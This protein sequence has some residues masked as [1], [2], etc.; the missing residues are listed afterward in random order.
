MHNTNEIPGA[1]ERNEI[2]PKPDIA[3]RKGK[4]RKYPVRVLGVI[5]LTAVILILNHIASLCFDRP[6][7]AD[8]YNYDMA[9][10]Q[11]DQAPVDMIIVG[12]SQV[13]HGCN[14]MVISEQMNIGE[15]VDCGAAVG[16]ADGLYYMLRDLLRRFTPECV[17][18]DMPWHRFREY[19]DPA[20]RTGMYLCSDRLNWSDKLDYALHCYGLKDW[21]NLVPVYRYGE[22]V[23]SLGQLLKNYHNKK[24]VAEGRWEEAGKTDY[25]K[26]GFKWTRKSCPQGSIPALDEFYSEEQNSEYIK[27]YIR[28]MQQLCEE[29][30]IPVIFITIPRSMMELYSVEN[31]QGAADYITEFAK[32]LG[33]P[34]LN[35]NYL[36]DREEIMTDSLF[37]DK[38]HLNGE[39]SVVFSGILADA[40]QKTLDG[41][42][43]SGLFYRNLSELK[44]DVHR[45][46]ACNGRVWPNGDGTLTVEAKSFQNEDVT[47]QYRL[48][49][50]K[51]TKTVSEDDEADGENA[52][53]VESILQSVEGES[54]EDGEAEDALFQVSE[55]QVLRPWQ[56]ETVFLLNE[57]EI[58]EG[59]ALRLETRR[60]GQE[61]TEAYVNRLTD[62]FQVKRNEG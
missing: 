10:L 19:R 45:I 21:A 20:A 62:E 40:V 44:E 31:Y 16:Y 17:V 56:E 5:V 58:P 57:E 50:I 1:E 43:V 53:D 8:Y 52:G 61:R 46:V 23:W 33:C 42:D 41:E 32:E 36:K 9:R 38:V 11:K 34:Y 59:Y 29:K 12:A 6:R 13:Y 60:K 39:G 54:E 30:G 2:S 4:P 35:F 18:I 27:K 25:Q 47:P 28:M 48:M 49:L 55:L 51:E 22:S 7:D 26:N 14:P 15:V 37:S 24:A 3:G